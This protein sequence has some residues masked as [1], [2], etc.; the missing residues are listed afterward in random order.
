M[1]QSLAVAFLSVLVGKWG[2][3]HSFHTY[4]LSTSHARPLLNAG[5]SAVKK[6]NSPSSHEADD[7]VGEPDIK[8]ADKLVACRIRRTK[9]TKAEGGRGRGRGSLRQGSLRPT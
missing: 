4:V 5:D 3:I 9:Q 7:R 1:N 8:E 6:L 2:L